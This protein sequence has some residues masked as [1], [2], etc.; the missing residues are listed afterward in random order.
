MTTPRLLLALIQHL[1]TT[2]ELMFRL[3]LILRLKRVTGPINPM[4]EPE[5]MAVMVVE[6]M[7]EEDM[8]ATEVWV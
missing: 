8:G 3:E 4:E 1:L 6:D 7:A 2:L 5:A